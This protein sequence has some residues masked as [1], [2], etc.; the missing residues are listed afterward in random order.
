M[1]QRNTV[2]RVSCKQNKQNARAN[3]NVTRA[4]CM[5]AKQLNWTTMTRQKKENADYK[6]S[7]Q[8]QQT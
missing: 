1:V 4:A 3:Q 2:G 7:R 5:H 6:G 8:K